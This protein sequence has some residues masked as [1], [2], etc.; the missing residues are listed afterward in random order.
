MGQ[1]GDKVRFLC[2]PCARRA[3]RIVTSWEV[4]R[5]HGKGTPGGSEQTQVQELTVS[6]FHALWASPPKKGRRW[7]EAPSLSLEVLCERMAD[8]T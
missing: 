3:D 7:K 2:G 8:V 4:D 6:P 1:R 5:C